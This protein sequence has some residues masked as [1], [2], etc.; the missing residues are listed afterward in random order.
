[1]STLPSVRLDPIRIVSD[2]PAVSVPAGSKSRPLARPGK[3]CSCLRDG[4]G[5][6]IREQVEQAPF[7]FHR[8]DVMSTAD[9]FTQ[10]PHIPRSPRSN[11]KRRDFLAKNEE[12]TEEESIHSNDGPYLEAI[13]IEPVAFPMLPWL[14][15]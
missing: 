12:S 2:S 1:V 5:P 3:T 10:T 7:C 9:D 15:Q 4:P 6:A 11:D 14:A 8:L 13:A